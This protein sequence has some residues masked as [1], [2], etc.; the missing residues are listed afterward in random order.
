LTF[1]FATYLKSTDLKG[2]L[3]KGGVLEKELRTTVLDTA[4]IKFLDHSSREALIT[5]SVLYV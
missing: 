3:F 4:V 2:Q 5:V 1:V